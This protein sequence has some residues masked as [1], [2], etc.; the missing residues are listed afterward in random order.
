[1]DFA[2][3]ARKR[4]AVSEIIG[5][6]LAIAITLIAGAAAWGYV[7]TQAATSE[8]ALQNNVVGTN[9]FLNERFSLIDMYFTTS[10]STSFWV[11]NTG[12][13]T[14]QAFS[15]RLYDS[16]GLVNLMFNYTQSGSVRT[17]YVYDLRSSL[18]TKCKTAATSYETPSLTATT[19]MGTIAQIYSLTIPPALANCPSFGQTFGSGTTYTLVLTGIYGNTAA[20]SRLK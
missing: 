18:T 8:S 3:R 10:T 6:V 12:S 13:V 17:D 16:A 19:V 20:Y 4:P 1:M 11:Y 7:R 9:N 14:L 2:R 15:V 5:S